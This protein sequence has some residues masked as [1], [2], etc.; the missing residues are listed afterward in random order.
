MTHIRLSAD[1]VWPETI[2]T[3]D[4]GPVPIPDARFGLTFTGIVG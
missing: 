2:H 4:L 3:G 1:S